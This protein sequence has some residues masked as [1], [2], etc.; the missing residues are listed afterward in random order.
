G[1][2]TWEGRVEAMGTI[3]VCVCAQE[4]WGKGTD[5]LAGKLGYSL[6]SKAFRVF[7]KRTKKIEENLHV[8]F[9]ENKSFDIDTLT[10]SMNYVPVV[11]AGTS[12]TNISVETEVPSVS[13]HVP[14]DLL[15]VSP[16][17]SSVPRIISRGGSSFPKPISLGNV[18]SF[19]NRLE[20][21]FRDTSNAVCLNEVEADLSNM[22]TAI[23]VSPTLTF[24]IHK[25]HPKSYNWI[26]AIRLFLAYASYMGFTV[27]QMYVKS[28]F[29][30]GTID[31]EVYVMQPPGFQDP[32]FSHRV[33]KVEKAMYGLHQ[34]SRTW[35]GTLSKY[36]LDNGF[37][38]DIRAAKTP[39]DRENRWGKDGTGKD[40]ELH[41]YRSMI[42]SLKYLTASRPY[43]MFAVYSDY[44]GANQDRKSTTGGCQLLGRR[45]ISWQCKKQTIVATSTTKAEYVTTASGCGQVLWI[46]IQ[47]LDYGDPMVNMC[48]TFLYGSDI[49]QRTH[50]FMH[51]YLA[52]AS[53]AFCDYHN[54]VA[55]L[56]KTEH[57][58]DF[59]QIMDFLDASH[60][61]YALTIHPTVYVSHI[62]QFWA[63]ERIETTDEETK[64]L[65][66]VNG[67][68]K[69]TSFNEFS[70]N[71]ATA[72][73][74]LATN[75]T[76]NFS[77]MIFD[78]MIRNVKS[79]GKFIMYPRIIEKLLKMSQF[80]VIKH[81]KVYSVPFHTQKGEGSKHTYEPHHTPSDQDE[82]I[83][84]KQI[85]QSPQHAQIT[86]HEPI[87]Q[88]HKQTT[89]Q[90]PTI[91]S[92]SHSVITTR[93]R[94]TRGTI[95]ISQSKV[96]SPR[97]D[98]TAFSIGDVR[99]GKAF[100]TD[101]SLDA[102]QDRE[103]IAKT[104]A[105]PYE[106]LLRVTSLGVGEGSMQQKLQ[107]L[108][109]ICTSLQRKHSVMEERVQSQDL[110]I[111]QLKARVKTLEDN[112]RR[113]EGFAQDDA[114]NTEGWIKG[115]IC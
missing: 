19:E 30:Y 108:M 29:L 84:H 61:R 44:G 60:I 91:P 38:R 16:I 99:Y 106:A 40:V 75:R 27:Y 81:T 43:I 70:S 66:K 72:L 55:I 13:T 1:K 23:Q 83:H 47:L 96:P 11:V 10:N 115:R 105:M 3:P 12:S 92:Q 46:Q 82:P 74:C 98:E 4:S 26:E 22:E 21:F 67:S 32:E 6:S 9:L 25:D 45:L 17:T 109:D 95:W 78:G 62:R 54:M 88:S 36:F 73:V 31:E 14:T 51:I 64:I 76:Y 2:G 102:G 65:A 113:R 50:E 100:P 89:S 80:G 28:A 114:P 112:E 33:Y 85:T 93:R 104:S 101:T 110:E 68:P 77:K 94:I 7:N 103:N 87:P 5:V 107:E 56:E 48:L 42:E 69:N 41:L 57:N 71:I 34:A 111:T 90:E 39:M 37:Q 49:E 63:T 59:H 58:T 8:D 20:D 86:S 97:A 35:Y 53:L 79:N 18:V 24:R 15:S 52:F